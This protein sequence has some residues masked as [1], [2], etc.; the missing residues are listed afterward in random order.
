MRRGGMMVGFE[1][2]ESKLPLI[3]LWFRLE[4]LGLC[5]IFILRKRDPLGQFLSD[6]YQQSII[7][8]AMR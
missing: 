8:P 5:L 4:P 6:G 7:C 3:G 1:D 2:E